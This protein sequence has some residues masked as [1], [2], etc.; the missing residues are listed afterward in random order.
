MYSLYNIADNNVH[1]QSYV[2]ENI[3]NGK[4]AF[5][6][7]NQIANFSVKNSTEIDNTGIDIS[8]AS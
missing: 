4:T 8:Y 7:N 1:M 6:I 2:V 3:Y 5:N